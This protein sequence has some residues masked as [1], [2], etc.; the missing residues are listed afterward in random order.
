MD[1]VLTRKVV[2]NE[3][4]LNRD[5]ITG[6]PGAHPL[7]T[8]AGAASGGV[9]GAAIGMG[10][11]A[12]TRMFRQL[13]VPVFDA[14]AEVHDLQGP[15]GALLGAIIGAVAGGLAGKEAAESLNPTAEEI[16]WREYYTQE[17][18]AA[19][20]KSY[21]YY[22]PAYQIGWEGRARYPK[23]TFE[24]AEAQMQTDYAKLRTAQAAE[25]VEARAAAYAAWNRIDHSWKSAA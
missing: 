16:Y 17:P 15:G 23:L 24:E 6:T 11:S 2:K 12:V 20:D 19:R 3:E 10:K 5:P 8:G 9:A 14:D 13:G 22:A 4:D 18:Y 21:E 7:G 25:W 1:K